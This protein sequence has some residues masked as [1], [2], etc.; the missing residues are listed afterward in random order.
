[1]FKV[2]EVVFG[3]VVQQ[4]DLLSTVALEFRPERQLGRSER[5]VGHDHDGAEDEDVL[6]EKEAPARPRA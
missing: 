5:S 6:H 3:N 2:A 4:I 1:M